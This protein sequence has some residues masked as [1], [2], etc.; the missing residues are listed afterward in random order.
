MSQSAHINF[1]IKVNNSGITRLGFGLIGVLSH[2]AAL[3]AGRSKLYTRTADA[4]TDGFP[5]DGPEVRALTRIFGQSPHPP[6]AA[7]L[8]A[9]DVAVIQKYE[10]DATVADNTL[11]QLVVEGEGF[12]DATIE[13][14]TGDDATQGLVHYELLTGLNAI[15]DKN[16]TA[17][18][19]ALVYADQVFTAAAGTEIF[20]KA[21]H[22][23]QTG[24]GPFQV[25]NSGGA[26]PAG[27]AAVTDYWIIRIDANTFYLAT[28]LANAVAGSH[29]S[30]STDGT[31]TQTISDTGS[32][33][34]PSDPLVITGT[35][36]NDWFSLSSTEIDLIAL[37]Q[38]HD[39]FDV[40]TALSA[41]LLKDKSWYWLETNFNSKS[42]VLAVAEWC[43]AN[44]KTYIA[45]VNETEACTVVVGDGT[46]TLAALLALEYKRTLYCFHHRPAAMMS[47]GYEG[48]LAPK[49]PGLW[50][51]AYKP[52]I[53]VE[54][55]PLNESHM[56]NLDAR[57]ATYYKQEFDRSFTW[58]G[59]VA[60]PDYG[61]LDV[62]VSLDWVSDDFVKSLAGKFIASDSIGYDDADFMILIAAGRG[63]I[64]RA[65]S[66]EHKIMA[67]G[68]PDN[69]LDPPPSFTLPRVADIDPSVRALRNIPDGQLTFRL[70]S[71][72]HSADVTA[73]VSF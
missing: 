42:Y 10:L 67:P 45:D 40:A 23:L 36:A 1:Q 33:V 61:F 13:Y 73:T 34:R 29:L 27:I 48:E 54:A 63:S 16:F 22:T 5:A 11:Y 3:F 39:D 24:D 50:T 4:I 30:I 66:N 14:T 57:R 15:V 72:A 69:P 70:R 12:D 17:A 55:S 59:K 53:G 35:A 6:R 60:N 68:D 2:R 19:K 51:A 52:I 47:A 7:I 31:G 18:Y 26:L 44:A 8:R 9:D 28:S 38:T 20:T 56:A 64:A 21:G 58:E 49:N 25:S 32:T 71:S 37:K 46:D 41:I 62:T 65:V 43:E